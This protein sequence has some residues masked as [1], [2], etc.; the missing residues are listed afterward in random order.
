LSFC[1]DGE[2]GDG[3]AEQGFAQSDSI[4]GGA[5]HRSREGMPPDRLYSLALVGRVSSVPTAPAEAV[6]TGES[7]REREAVGLVVVFYGRWV[8]VCVFP[9]GYISKE[10][11]R[12]S[13]GHGAGF[14]PTLPGA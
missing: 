12:G 9:V 1:G 7:A 2:T 10:R 5:R 8:C 11:E 6:V 13:R 4:T 14:F 3:R